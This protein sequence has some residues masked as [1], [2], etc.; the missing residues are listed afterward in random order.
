MHDN[1][2]FASHIIRAYDMAGRKEFIERR[3]Q[4]RFQ[5]QDGAF[6]AI[7]GSASKVGQ[8]IDISRGGLA[9]RYIANGELSN[10][11]AELDILLANNRFL[12][13]KVPFKTISDFEID[14]EIPFTFITMRRLGVQFGDLLD[15]HTSQLEYFIQN[16][17]IAEL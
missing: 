9:F 11:A 17:T 16:H 3:N 13:E 2:G 15:S 12:L 1:Q 8:I 10:G 4:K 7:R 5:A 14:K 6:A